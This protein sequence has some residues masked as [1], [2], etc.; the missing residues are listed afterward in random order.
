MPAFFYF[1]IIMRKYFF[2]AA[3]MALTVLGSCTREQ[4]SDAV[5]VQMSLETKVINTDIDA[6]SSTMLVKLSSSEDIAS[7]ETLESVKSVSR[8]FTSVPGNEELEAQFGL[9]RWVEISLEEGTALHD[10]A[11]ILS[12][13]E[14]VTA[15]QYNTVMQKSAT[16]GLY[17]AEPTKAD[18]KPIFSDP[19]LKDQWHYINTGSKMF[20]DYTVAGAD[21]NVK[22]VWTRLTCGD[23]E[24]IVGIVDEGVKHT[25]PD[26][27]GNMWVN[28]KEIPGNGI[29]DDKNGYIDDVYGY[30][31]VD[32][33]GTISWGK[34]GDS[35]HGTHTAGTVAAVNNNGIGVSGV[36]GGS[37]KNDG[38]RI[39][40][41]QVF[42]GGYGGTSSAISKAIKY[43]A[44]N[45]ASVINCSFGS[46]VQ[47]ASDNQYVS[48][49]GGIEIDAIRYFEAHKGNNP[50]LKDGNIAVFA[51]GNEEHPFAHY[52]GATHDIISVSAFAPD[53]LPAYYTN[54][55]PGCNI[56]APGGEMTLCSTFASMVLSTI[57]SEVQAQFDSKVQ[58]GFDYAYMQGTS[59]ACP[60]V[61]G[62]VAL[63]LSYA[64]KQG[65][66][67]TRDEFKQMILSS[68]NDIDQKIASKKSKSYVNV[69]IDGGRYYPAHADLTMAP[70]YH[71]M[72]AGAIDAWR[73]MM[74]IDGTPCLTTQIGAT[75][76]IDLSEVLGTSSVSLTYLDV[77]VP[78]TTIDA[79]G[80]EKLTPVKASGTN[81]V[82]VPQAECYA[83]E[84]F[85]R[86]YVHATKPGSGKLTIRVIGGGD[87]L[88]GGDN[89]TG[90]M[91][92]DAEVSLVSRA[93]KS[94]N[95]GWL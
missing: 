13:C 85:G 88:G 44:D 63:A 43:A 35:G 16:G 46:R 51:A 89:P 24:I 82:P 94:N 49:G 15:V 18:E 3:I 72:G 32:N 76:W 39:M 83:Y 7:L 54:Y 12:S 45:G 33:S 78:Q 65:R 22:D 40:S 56:A 69:P 87:H 8:V 38:C 2:S 21:I 4:L 14:S 58:K 93:V 86:L 61:T 27:I 28:T 60:H 17:A 9:D 77:I 74:K 66:S 37:G 31:F 80:L 48:R 47:F 73:L 62:V 92:I 5:P 57:P 10:M 67:F 55:G 50:V 42:S 81:G 30:N 59:M 25:H 29:D 84:Q 75:S 41:C 11:A 95:G 20:G 68:T 52:P 19:Y 90:G 71:Q 6:D 36:A 1:C 23:P 64:K 91:E 34:D 26:L 70:Y 53:F 79:L